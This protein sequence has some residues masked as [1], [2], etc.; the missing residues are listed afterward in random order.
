MRIIHLSDI[1]LSKDNFEEFK[2][3]FRQALI[4]DLLDF[5][6]SKKIDVIVITGDLVDKGGDSLYEIGGFENKTKYPSPYDIFEEIFINPI[7]EALC[8]SR[9]NFLFVPGNHDVDESKILLKEEYEFTKNLNFDN[10]DYHLKEN[11]NFKYS[12]R[13]RKF[14]EFE[15][16]FHNEQSNYRYSTNQSICSYDFENLKIG[17]IL[18]NDSWRCRSQILKCDDRL[19]FGVN[20]FYNGLTTLREY[21]TSVNIALLHHPIENFRENELLERC[22]RISNISFYLFGHYHSNEFKKHYQGSLDNCFGIRGRSSLN[23]INESHPSY[24]PGYQIIDLDFQ[25][26]AMITA[27]HYRQYKYKFNHFDYDSDACLGGI[28]R[29]KSNKGIEIKS[30]LQKNKQHSLNKSQFQ[31]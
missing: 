16:K 27:I 23:K 12:E 11:S 24:Q 22:L 25:F 2:N 14:K 20:Q 9:E 7:I 28:D 13:I 8:F 15:E 4:L 31:S 30:N 29:G 3:T 18:V 1:H 21:N 17:F 6:S 10:I 19:M 26:K 5:N